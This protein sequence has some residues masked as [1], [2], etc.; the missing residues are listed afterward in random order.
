M[1]DS[2]LLFVLM[3]FWDFQIWF[4]GL[5]SHLCRRARPRTLTTPSRKGANCQ[6][7]S[8]ERITTQMIHFALWQAVF[9]LWRNV[10]QAVTQTNYKPVYPQAKGP[11]SSLGFLTLLLSIMREGMQPRKWQKLALFQKDLVYINGA[12]PWVGGL[13]CSRLFL[14]LEQK[15][16]HY[17]EPRIW[18]DFAN[19]RF[20][21][22]PLRVAS[23][24]SR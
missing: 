1:S 7:G 21:R 8:T 23:L 4:K 6:A 3:S 11:A 2:G 14:R 5:M 9:D 17:K 15:A 24:P 19:W 20:Q 16:S 13:M 12:C 10:L 22:F 18:S